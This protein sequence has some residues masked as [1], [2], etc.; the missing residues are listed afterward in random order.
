LENIGRVKKVK[1]KLEK[2]LGVKISI[3]KEVLIS[4]KEENE[5]LAEKILE[6][7]SFGFPLDEA[8]LLRDEDFIFE[9][10]QIPGKSGKRKEE[11]KGRV[12]GK[13]GRVREVLEQLSDSSIRIEENEVGIIA[14]AEDIKYIIQAIQ[15][16]LRGSKHSNV[17]TFLESHRARKKV[18]RDLGLRYREKP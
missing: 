2:E 9:K 15:N 14:V 18:P 12:I 3:G 6:A 1:S 5:F 4:G 13:H 17:F 16:M 7:I 8:L 10:I 11:I